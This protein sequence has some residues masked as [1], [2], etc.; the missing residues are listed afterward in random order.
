MPF[1]FFDSIKPSASEPG[2]NAHKSSALTQI[3]SSSLASTNAVIDFNPTTQI[4]QKFVQTIIGFSSLFRP[5][6]TNFEKIQNAL[7]GLLAAAHLSLTTTSL[8]QNLNCNENDSNPICR[9][10]FILEIFYISLLS[11]GWSVGEITAAIQ[12]ATQNLPSTTDLNSKKI[13]AFTEL[14]GN[15]IASLSDNDT[16]IIQIPQKI[17]QT[18]A[19]FYSAFNAVENKERA[20][21]AALGAFA[22]AQ[23]VLNIILLVQGRSCENNADLICK[24][25]FLF[26]ALYTGTLSLGWSEGEIKAYAQRI[27]QAASALPGA[28]ANNAPNHVG[29]P[30]APNQVPQQPQQTTNSSCTI[31]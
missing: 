16:P 14:V 29:I 26:K 3:V 1:T 23:L 2:L 15:F 20:Q 6:V 7:L 30:I 9:S 22:L 25:C 21:N 12:H 28:Q 24:L 13:A 17:I 8:F 18:I 31:I 19:G 4:P 11:L 10:I 27:Q 5:D